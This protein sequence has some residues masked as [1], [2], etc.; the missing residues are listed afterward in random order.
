MCRLA[1][2][3]EERVHE[4]KELKES[5]LGIAIVPSTTSLLLD[6]KRIVNRLENSYM[7]ILRQYFTYEKEEEKEWLK[8]VQEDIQERRRTIREGLKKMSK[9]VSKGKEAHYFTRQLL[10]EYAVFMGKL[11]NIMILSKR[12]W[13]ED[14]EPPS[15]KDKKIIRKVFRVMLKYFNDISKSI[16]HYARDPGY[17]KD[18]EFIREKVKLV[19]RKYEEYVGRYIG[20]EVEERAEKLLKKDYPELYILV[21]NESIEI[22]EYNVE[23]SDDSL[24]KDTEQMGHELVNSVE[25]FDAVSTISKLSPIVRILSIRYSDETVKNSIFAMSEDLEKS[26][27]TTFTKIAIKTRGLVPR[28]IEKLLAKKQASMGGGG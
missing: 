11:K 18:R 9:V 5:E 10:T 13:L 20:E 1:S 21:K 14:E 4:L 17:K 12:S 25:R 28:P 7:S 22:P 8:E 15:K 6:I 26:F 19:K 27:F 16:L 2:R 3:Y 24:I 23:I